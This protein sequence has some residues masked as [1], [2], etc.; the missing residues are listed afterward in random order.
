MGDVSDITGENRTL[1]T[2][3]L[4][5]L[6]RSKR[7]GVQA[8]LGVA[9]TNV[10]KL[11]VEAVGFQL[12]PRIN[13]AARMEDPWL[14]VSLLL[15]TEPAEAMSTAR[16]LNTLNNK[17]QEITDQ[18]MAEIE[19]R[20]GETLL[21]HNV[22]SWMGAGRRGSWIDRGQAARGVFPPGRGHRDQ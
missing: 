20:Y 13:A 16:Q 9:G 12:A 15:A 18:A 3:G 19:K 2:L 6:K 11:N 14:S 22:S 4:E 5:I 7:P 17:R 21:E 10:S 8:L 1:V